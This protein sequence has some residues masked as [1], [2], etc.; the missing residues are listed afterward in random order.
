MASKTPDQS[1]ADNQQFNSFSEFYPYYL[2]EHSDP[3]S[4]KL[5]YIGSAIAPAVLLIALFTG[6]LWLLALVPVSGYFFAWVGHFFL[7]KNKPAT[8]THP[9]WSLMGDYKMLWQALTGTLD[10]RHFH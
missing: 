1:A 6:P 4:R 8:F 2:G 10:K 9:L 7:E 5:H 3:R